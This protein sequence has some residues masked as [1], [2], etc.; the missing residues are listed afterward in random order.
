MSNFVLKLP[1]FFIIARLNE[2]FR[3][4]FLHFRDGFGSC[5]FNMNYV[6]QAADW[7][8]FQFFL[9]FNEKF[10]FGL[11]FVIGYEF[12]IFFSIFIILPFEISDINPCF[13]QN[14]ETFMVFNIFAAIN[15]F[16]KSVNIFQTDLKNFSSLNF[17]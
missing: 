2:I 17:C 12:Q 5:S 14:F 3:C 8:L 16:F 11:P 6:F 4:V 15:L 9:K 7:I 10:I 13:F 1:I